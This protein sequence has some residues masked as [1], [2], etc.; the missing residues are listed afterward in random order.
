MMGATA[1]SSLTQESVEVPVWMSA[2]APAWM[3]AAVEVAVLRAVEAAVPAAVARVL[4]DFAPRSLS[5][6]ESL[7]PLLDTGGGGAGAV[8]G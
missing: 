2:E 3:L 6:L 1:S 5:Y 4:E 7:P 8:F